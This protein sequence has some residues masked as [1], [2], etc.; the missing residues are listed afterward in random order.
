MPIFMGCLF[1]MGAYYPDFTVLYFNNLIIDY[2]II[3]VYTI[4]SSVTVKLYLH[5]V[6]FHCKALLVHTKFFFSSLP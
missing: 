2:S 1:S 4:V 5:T 6:L 3:N